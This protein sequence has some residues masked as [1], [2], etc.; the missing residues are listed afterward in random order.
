MNEVPPPEHAGNENW[1][2]V[3]MF[4]D[5]SPSFAY[6]AE[7]GMVYERLSS[8][9]FKPQAVR[10]ENQEVLKAAAAHFGQ[11]AVF[12]ESEVEGWLFMD[13]EP[14]KLSVV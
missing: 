9:T 3:L 13:L 6:G 2:P 5:E 12:T 7:F 10:V 8:K 1:K 4:T 11:V 14:F